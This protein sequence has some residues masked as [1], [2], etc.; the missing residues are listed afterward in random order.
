MR[1]DVTNRWGGYSYSRRIVAAC[2]LFALALR[3]GSS[4]VW[5]DDLSNDWLARNVPWLTVD[6]VYTGE[7]FTNARGGVSSKNATHYQG[8]L[9]LGLTVDLAR[10]G[11]IVPGTFFLL[12]Q[13]THGQGITDEFVGDTLV[14]SN[15]DASR[16]VMQVSEYWWE[17]SPHDDVTLR[18]GK[19]D[20]N[21]EFAF[22]ESAGDFVQSTFGLSPS[23]AFP[24]YPNQAMGAIAL[25]DLTE[26]LRF[27]AGVWNAFASG[28]SW[29]LSGSDS[30]LLA[31][32]LELCYSWADLPGTVAVGAIYESNGR[33]DGQPISDVHEYIFQWEQL[34]FRKHN[35]TITEE[36]LSLF[37]GYY[38]RFPGEQKVDESI[39]SSFVAG[40]VYRG[41]VPGREDDSLGAGYATAELFRGGTNRESIFELYYRIAAT[42]SLII[43]PDLQYIASPSGI[44]RD[45]L[46]LGVRVQTDW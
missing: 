33:I 31:T 12:G 16:N 46:A 13:N 27:K 9:D 43:Q 10:L 39:G 30:V 29:G 17:F 44:V 2:V 26:Q 25:V 18:L 24:T 3:V 23:T 32:E 28:S 35:S 11:C 1:K 38:P 7:V 4:R 21:T 8:L 45:A 42:S 40:L 20:F 36:G 19:Q 41:L 22:I 14:L 6:S 37:C 34:V 5:A 15:L